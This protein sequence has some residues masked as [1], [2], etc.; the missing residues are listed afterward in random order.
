MNPEQLQQLIKWLNIQIVRLTESIQEAHQTNNY[1]REL[2]YQGMRDAFQ[3]FL[4]KFNNANDEKVKSPNK[5]S[6]NTI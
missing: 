4:N 5:R 3:K 6:R 2:Q 1:G